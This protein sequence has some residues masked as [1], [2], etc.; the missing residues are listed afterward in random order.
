M[1]SNEICF[2][3]LFF[4]SFMIMCA[5]LCVYHMWAFRC[6][7]HMC[8]LPDSVRLPKNCG[9]EV[10]V[11][12]VSHVTCVLGTMQLSSSARVVNILNCW[13]FLPVSCGRY[14]KP[15]VLADF[16]KCFPLCHDVPRRCLRDAS[17]LILIFLAPEIMNNTF[18]L[19]RICTASGSL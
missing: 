4:L 8:A 9:V 17:S 6:V 18:L 19:I 12:F 2:W 7:Y 14:S 3:T 11:R 13:A 1:L 16:K 5:F 15:I 10:F